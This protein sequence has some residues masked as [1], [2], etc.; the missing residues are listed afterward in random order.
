MVDIV[1]PATSVSDNGKS[2]EIAEAGETV[3][4]RNSQR[5]DAGT[6]VFPPAVLAAF[7]A[8]CRAGELDDLT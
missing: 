7:V 4:V 5:P 6:L 3:L 2:V 8:A 1:W